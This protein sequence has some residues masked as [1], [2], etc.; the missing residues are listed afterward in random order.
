VAPG[1][2][3]VG[4]RWGAG[5]PQASG[6]SSNDQRMHSMSAG[7]DGAPMGAPRPAPKLGVHT[8]D[9]L[10]EIGEG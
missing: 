3:D 1:D 8:A 10:R 2:L 6:K 9:I 5:A 4:V 7:I